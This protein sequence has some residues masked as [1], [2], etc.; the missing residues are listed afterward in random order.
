MAATN[1]TG[2][3]GGNRQAEDIPAY[4]SIAP[5][6]FVPAQTDLTKSPPDLPSELN[7]LRSEA[8][9]QINGHADAVQDNIYFMLDREKMR[10]RQE[11]RQREAHFSPHL[12][13]T[14][15]LEEGEDQWLVDST[16]GVEEVLLIRSIVNKPERGPYEVPPVF[17]H[18][19]CLHAELDGR[20]TPRRQA[21]KMVLNL[22][23]HGVQNLEGLAQHVNNV[24]GAKSRELENEMLSKSLGSTGVAPADKME[25]G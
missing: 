4:Q 3:A 16:S 6:T 11:C 22:A 14:P 20:E 7:E 2:K 21:E 12:Q 10:I 25:I 1:N 23:K 18:L 17:T 15:G 19:Q 9:A 24:K 8:F 5:C 13:V